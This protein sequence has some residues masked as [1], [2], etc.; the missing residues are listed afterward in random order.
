MWTSTLARC[1]F[2]QPAI[3]P[4]VARGSPWGPSVVTVTGRCHVAGRQATIAWASV[5]CHELVRWGGRDLSPGRGR[6]GASTTLHKGQST[7][8]VL[9]R[10]SP[11]FSRD[12]SGVLSTRLG[13]ATEIGFVSEEKTPR[14]A[15]KRRDKNG[16]V[17]TETEQ[18]QATPWGAPRVLADGVSGCGGSGDRAPQQ[19]SWFS[20]D[21]YFYCM[22][23]Y[24]FQWRLQQHDAVQRA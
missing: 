2:S 16:R 17:V 11:C 24:V 12:S 14:V 20:E 1:S 7:I 8:S 18:T 5:G 13:P 3:Q 19:K 10:F 9:L 23:F 21:R 22:I 4:V 15:C 6:E